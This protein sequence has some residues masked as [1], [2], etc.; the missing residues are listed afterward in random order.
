AFIFVSTA[1]QLQKIREISRQVPALKQIIVC[2][3]CAPSPPTV[4]T[5]AEKI[6]HGKTVLAADPQMVRNRAA[7]SKPDDVFSIIY[8]SGTTG[9]PKGVMLTHDNVLSNVRAVR[10]LFQILNTDI[11]L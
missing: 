4:F 7:E 5:L 10:D 2:D 6:A 11:A 8:T 3:E 1:D 9:E